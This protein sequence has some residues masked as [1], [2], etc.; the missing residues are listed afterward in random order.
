MPLPTIET[1][2]T[3][4]PSCCT[5][6]DGVIECAQRMAKEDVGAV[7]VVESQDT[8]RLVGVITDRDLCLSVVAEGRDPAEVSVGDCMTDEVITVTPDDTLDR[9]LELMQQNQIRRLCVV[10]ENFCCIG[11]LAQADVARAASA[12]QLKQ[13]LGE[14]SSEKSH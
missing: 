11:M 1:L 4:D 13:T 12:A 14:L 9:A 8:R 2:M 3:R 10:D 6:D 7:P 5:P